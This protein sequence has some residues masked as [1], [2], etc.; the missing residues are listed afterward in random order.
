MPTRRRRPLAGRRDLREGRGSL[1]LRLPR[2]RSIRAGYRRIRLTAAGRRRRPAVLPAGHRRDQG[3]PRRGR[4]RPGAGVSG[5]AGCAAASAMAPYRPLRQQPHRMRPRAAEGAAPADARAQTGP[6]CH[7]R[8]GWAC[9][10][11]ERSVRLL[12]ARGRGASKAFELPPHS[13][14]WLW[15][16][17]PSAGNGFGCHPSTRCNRAFSR[18]LRWP[19]RK[20]TGSRSTRRTSP[21]S[22]RR[23]RTDRGVASADPGRRPTV[24]PCLAVRSTVIFV[25]APC[26]W[27]EPGAVSTTYKPTKFPDARRS[28]P[29]LGDGHMT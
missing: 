27:V 21:G 20:A 24:R 2:D 19:T 7:G 9:L 26:S 22:G 10:G 13:T 12:R 23:R 17:D 4:N 6:Q 25:S 3:H 11:A 8:A 28:P 5:G 1:A 14:S 15:R 29:S 16:S 18:T